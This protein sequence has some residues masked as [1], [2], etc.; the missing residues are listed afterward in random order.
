[1]TILL[2]LRFL[3]L[4]KNTIIGNCNKEEDVAP[5]ADLSEYGSC[6]TKTA[7]PVHDPVSVLSTT[8]IIEQ[9]IPFP[10]YNSRPCSFSFK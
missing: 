5:A 9:K 2:N 7:A 6:P 10:V 3:L 4:Q 8:T 1:M